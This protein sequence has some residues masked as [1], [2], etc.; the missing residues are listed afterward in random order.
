MYH[1]LWYHPTICIVLHKLFFLSYCYLCC[2][3]MAVWFI[4][5]AIK[6]YKNKTENEKKTVKCVR[7]KVCKEVKNIIHSSITTSLCPYDIHLYNKQE[8]K[9]YQIQNEQL[10]FW[11]ASKSFGYFFMLISQSKQK[12]KA[13]L[14]MVI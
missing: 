5:P 4:F 12:P 11:N 10:Y 8:Q 2:E 13:N 6:K 7:I 3:S 9:K 1:K 14:F